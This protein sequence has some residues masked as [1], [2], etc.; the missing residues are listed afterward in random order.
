VTKATLH[1][2]LMR[3]AGYDVP[4][5]EARERRRLW[6]RRQ[7]RRGVAF[8]GIAIAAV[9]VA[10]VEFLGDNRRLGGVS[11]LLMILAALAVVRE[12]TARDDGESRS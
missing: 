7:L 3:E 10:G 1:D 4:S 8:V 2:E 5:L 11:I 9:I 12:M 6:R